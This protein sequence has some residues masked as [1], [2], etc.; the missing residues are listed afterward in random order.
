MPDQTPQD[1]GRMGRHKSDDQVEDRERHQ[2]MVVVVND[3]MQRNYRYIR[4]EPVGRNF[5]PEFKPELTPKELLALG[6]FGGKYMTDCRNEFL[7]LVHAG[8]AVA[9]GK[10][11]RPKLFRRGCEPAAIGVA[12]ERLASR[13]RSARLVPMVLPVFHGPAHARG[14]QAPDQA[15][16][17]L[18]AAH[19]ADQAEL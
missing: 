17:S 10:E 3:K 19:R 2:G 13:R 15:M 5:D 7:E 9:V 12:P 14:G 1:E 6:V 11:R 4:V 8:Q 18:P 16:E